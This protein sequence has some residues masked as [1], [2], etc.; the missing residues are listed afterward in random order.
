M[1]ST[2]EEIEA[3]F[4]QQRSVADS[5]HSCQLSGAGPLSTQFYEVL[6]GLIVS[7]DLHPGQLLSEQEIAEAF[8]ASKTPVREALIRLEVARLVKIVPKSGTYV[9]PIDLARYK[10]ACFVRLSLEA[11]AI[12][13]AAQNPD[14]D[15]F[16]TQLMMMITEQERACRSGDY[17]AYFKADVGLHKLFVEMAGVAG[18][19]GAIERS[20]VDVFRIRHLLGMQNLGR[21][22]QAIADHKSIVVAVLAGDPDAAQAELVSHIGSLEGKLRILEE[23]PGILEFIEKLNETAHLPTRARRSRA[24][25][26]AAVKVEETCRV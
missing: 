11:S 2:V 22:K 25:K 15:S 26:A 6:R 12:R 24:V 1:V 19:W 20:Q 23:Q 4:A 5:L 9:M 13:L 7:L 16:A 3:R 18:V 10:E 21:S 8:S 14:R 17:P